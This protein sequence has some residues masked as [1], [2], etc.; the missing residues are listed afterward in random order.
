MYNARANE[1]VAL[2]NNDISDR[3][4]TDGAIKQAW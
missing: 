3:W 2:W 1:I 4:I